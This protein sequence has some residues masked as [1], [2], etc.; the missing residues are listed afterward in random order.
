MVNIDDVE[1]DADDDDEYVYDDD[2]EEDCA[3]PLRPSIQS[4]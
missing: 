1:E 4:T 3:R 2:E